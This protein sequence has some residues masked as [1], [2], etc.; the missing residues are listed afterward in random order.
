MAKGEFGK[1]AALNILR[2]LGALQVRLYSADE[3][4]AATVT[5][6]TELPAT[7]GYAPYTIN[8]PA[9]FF[10]APQP[11][12]ANTPLTT[13]ARLYAAGTQANGTQTAATNM[14]IGNQGIANLAA[15]TGAFGATANYYGITDTSG[16]I[17]YHTLLDTPVTV[18]AANTVVSFAA[19]PLLVTAT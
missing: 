12:A 16:N 19:H 14:W 18:S 9:T 17:Y 10:N 8:S 6:A 2:N 5:A 4:D 15:S 13:P 1:A 11:V 7:G 3:T